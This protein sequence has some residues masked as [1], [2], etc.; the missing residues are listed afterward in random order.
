MKI[1][2]WLMLIT[3]SVSLAQT[4]DVLLSK[5]EEVIFSFTTN[6]GKQVILAKDKDNKYIVYRYGTPNNIELQHPERPDRKS[7]ESFTYSY[8]LRGGGKENSGLDLN[9]V[10][11]S[12]NGYKYVIYNTYS[13]EDGSDAVGIKIIDAFGKVTDIKGITATISGALT[14]FR[15]NNLV[16]TGD[17]I[18]D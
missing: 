14:G 7:W 16:E 11:F 5:N 6:K 12:N 1:L 18:F 3:S 17:E 4:N 9:Y 8:Y 2:V 15:E 10:Q 13:A